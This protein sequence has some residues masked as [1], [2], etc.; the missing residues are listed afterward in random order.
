MYGHDNTDIFEN[1]DIG[2]KYYKLNKFLYSI[3]FYYILLDL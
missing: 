3:L 2:D 1:R